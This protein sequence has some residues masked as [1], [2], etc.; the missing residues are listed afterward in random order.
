MFGVSDWLGV[1]V[2]PPLSPPFVFSFVVKAEVRGSRAPPCPPPSSSLCLWLITREEEWRALQPSVSRCELRRIV[3]Q[4]MSAYRSLRVNILEPYSFVRALCK[5]APPSSNPPSNPSSTP[6]RCPLFEVSTVGLEISLCV[7]FPP[8][9]LRCL[10]F[11][12][13]DGKGADDDC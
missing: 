2:A 9:S 6:S 7:S 13:R 8:V 1:R 4:A 5:C 12:F 3:D 11:P 10:L